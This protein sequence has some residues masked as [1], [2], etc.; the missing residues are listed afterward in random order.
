MA[1]NKYYIL[2]K[3]EEIKLFNALNSIQKLNKYV[4]INEPSILDQIINI[5]YTSN[6][7]EEITTQL[8]NLDLSNY[9]EGSIYEDTMY[10]DETYNLERT[11]NFI[12]NIKNTISSTDVIENEDKKT[13][14]NE[15]LKGYQSD[16]YEKSENI[17]PDNAKID[18][19]IEKYKQIVDNIFSE[20]ADLAEKYGSKYD[21]LIQDGTVVRKFKD[22]QQIVSYETKIIN[23][24]KNV[25]NTDTSTD[26]DSSGKYYEIIIGKKKNITEKINEKINQLNRLYASLIDTDAYTA[27]IVYATIV[28]NCINEFI[29]DPTQDKA[30]L[31]QSQL[32]NSEEYNNL[33]ESYKTQIS[34]IINNIILDHD[35]DSDYI[36]TNNDITTLNNIIRKA[37]SDYNKDNTSNNTILSRINIVEQQLAN[38]IDE[39]NKSQEGYYDGIGDFDVIRDKKIPANYSNNMDNIS[40][41]Y[42]QICPEYT[43]TL[44]ITNGTK[45]PDSIQ[46]VEIGGSV[47][48]TITPNEGYE[49]PESIEGATLEENIV[50]IS[51]VTAN[52]EI[53]V[54]CPR[55]KYYWYLGTQLLTTDAE[56]EANGTVVYNRDEIDNPLN[57][58]DSEGNLTYNFYWH[59]SFGNPSLSSNGLPASGQLIETIPP[60]AAQLN[61]TNYN[62]YRFAKGA[63]GEQTIEWS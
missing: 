4:S 35:Y 31:L 18:R 58:E 41:V 24:I 50:T 23:T 10:C 38:L 2:T 5:L 28:N 29:E 20:N 34:D 21:E 37:N 47:S 53:N 19:Q 25:E 59:K 16:I 15:K 13:I 12:E 49:L 26:P 3:T 33:P 62:G 17:Y 1:D 46:Q 11:N 9:G 51:N 48:W 39:Y 22:N 56:I 61:L 30:E 14:L 52:T 57:L 54:E 8:D 55:I 43:V 60:I 7:V 45:E 36:Y 63:T 32:S 27:E 40:A 44:N 6:N 42:S